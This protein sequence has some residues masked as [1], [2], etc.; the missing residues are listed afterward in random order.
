MAINPE[1]GFYATGR[2]KEAT[3]RVWVRP[4]NG[5]VVINGR[6]I[7]EYFGRETSKMVLNQPLEIL[8]QKGKLDVTVNVRGGGLSGQAGAIRH[9]IARALCAFN[10]E[11]RPALKKAGFLTRDA[12]AVERKKYGQPGARRRFQ[13]SK[14]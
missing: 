4:G 11:F 1:L 5:A 12:R 13:F 7:N 10:P 9:G 8:E 14:R 3:A 6:D 2:R